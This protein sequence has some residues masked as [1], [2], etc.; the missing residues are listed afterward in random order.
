MEQRRYILGNLI[1]E[2][3]MENVIKNF[4]NKKKEI[5]ILETDRDYLDTW[6]HITI[7]LSRQL[8]KNNELGFPITESA[9]NMEK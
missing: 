8:K 7:K 6:D 4:I 9:I 2:G 1:N 3:S 5:N